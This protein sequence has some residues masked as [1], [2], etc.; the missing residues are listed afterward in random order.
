MQD[1]GIRVGSF[2]APGR[3]MPGAGRLEVPG[4]IDRYT[5]TARAETRIVVDARPVGEWCGRGQVLRWSLF[6]DRLPAPVLADQ[7]LY[8]H[9]SCYHS[10]PV[11][12]PVGGRYALL[13]YGPGPQWDHGSYRF[14]L[15]PIAR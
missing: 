1:F 7:L 5:F 11:K 12:L 10:D 3:P 9:G 4:S 2:V 8:S 15:V 6:S 14:V 13:V